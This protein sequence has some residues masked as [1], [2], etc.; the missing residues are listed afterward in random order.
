LKEFGVGVL[1][2]AF[3]GASERMTSYKGEA[4]ESM[5]DGRL[6]A[7]HIGDVC[8]RGA[9]QCNLFDV[10]DHGLNGGADDEKLRPPGGLRQ[11]AS[12]VDDPAARGSLQRASV[13]AD[14]QYMACQATF[15]GGQ[16]D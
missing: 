10:L 11:V 5:N 3:L 8:V 13:A 1:G 15:A 7:A 14:A 16:T 6:R 12:G 4:L 9:M 2:P